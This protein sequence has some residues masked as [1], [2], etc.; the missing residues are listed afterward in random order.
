MVGHSED[1]KLQ[2][3][4]HSNSHSAASNSN[5]S[6]HNFSINK[7]ETDNLQNQTH[8]IIDNITMVANHD[9]NISDSASLIPTAGNIVVGCNRKSFS[10]DSLLFS[11]KHRQCPSLPLSSFNIV[12][13]KGKQGQ[14]LNKSGN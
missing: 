2:Q 7:V 10:I 9:G 11:A 13:N 14:F 6:L 5:R 1:G 4:M 3:T 12:S 8:N